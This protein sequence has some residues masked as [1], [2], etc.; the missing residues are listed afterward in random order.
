MDQLD[1]VYV[2][3]PGTRLLLEES[4]LLVHLPDDGGRH[5]VPLLRVES[6]V[7][8]GGVYISPDVMRRCADLGIH[9]TWI[10]QNGK[11]VATVT[12][13]ES[14][15]GELRLAQYR[16]H[17]NPEHRVDLARAFVHG[18]IHNYRTLLLRAGRDATGARQ[19]DLRQIAARQG[20]A[21]E[22]LPRAQSLSE[23]LGVEGRA[24][25]DYFQHSHLLFTAFAP[26]GRSRRPPLDPA[27][28]CLSMGYALLRSST[29]AALVHVGLDPMI[30]YLHGV[31]GTKPS[32]ALD[33]MEEMRPLLVDRLVATLLNRG[34]I[35][36][37]KHMRR[38]PGG[39][40]EFTPDG[41]S[42]FI[43]LWAESRTRDWNH[44][45]QR[46]RLPA[47]HLPLIQAR[48]LARHLR[49]PDFPY[50]PWTTA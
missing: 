41:L 49:E 20:V 10:T 3:R 40:W 12:G 47:S 15:G 26:A 31:R 16:A 39:A 35:V 5:R 17:S 4:A 27:N 6:I 34:Q 25:R 13:T 29:H 50:E 45:V 48:L 33:L 11:L 46:R 1:T 21:L 36:P 9:I 7:A 32:L 23:V 37:S 2:T 24:A 19:R 8:W 43:N 42:T 44:A 30:G 18:K 28:C 22:Q 38:L 14:G